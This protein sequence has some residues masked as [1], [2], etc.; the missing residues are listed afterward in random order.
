MKQL[1][2]CTTLAVRP[3]VWC[4]ALRWRG[5][6]CFGAADFFSLHGTPA[7]DRRNFRNPDLSARASSV[8][9]S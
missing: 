8:Q 1:S 2:H 4:E 6:R 5:Q 3:M 7:I 9:V